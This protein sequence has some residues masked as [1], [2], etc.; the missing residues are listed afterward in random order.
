MP[1][2]AQEVDILVGVAKKKNTTQQNNRTHNTMK[3]VQ[4][5]VVNENEHYILNEYSKEDFARLI[6][7][8]QIYLHFRF[9]DD[10]WKHPTRCSMSNDDDCDAIPDTYTDDSYDDDC[11]NIVFSVCAISM[12]DMYK[13]DLHEIQAFAASA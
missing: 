11:A 9:D 4:S 13:S 6:D 8:S 3:Q 5:R 2:I 10:P 1:W 7:Y 12:K